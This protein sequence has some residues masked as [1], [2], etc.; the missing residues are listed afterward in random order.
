MGDGLTDPR[1]PGTQTVRAI[2]ATYRLR[3]FLS[4]PDA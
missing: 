2:E 1:T 3:Q 4:V